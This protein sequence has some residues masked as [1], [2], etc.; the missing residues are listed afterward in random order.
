M[1]KD[2]LQNRSDFTG[3]GLLYRHQGKKN[4]LFVR[5]EA[6]ATFIQPQALL[7]ALGDM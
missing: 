3:N 6:E 4:A 1:V 5:N 7:Y 2:D